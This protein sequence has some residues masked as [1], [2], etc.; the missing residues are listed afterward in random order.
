MALT[1]GLPAPGFRGYS[2]FVPPPQGCV[3]WGNDSPRSNEEG[4]ALD[5]QQQ[6]SPRSLASPTGMQAQGMPTSPTGTI[7]DA[8][9]P[10]PSN[11]V[12]AP[13]SPS[14]LDH[15]GAGRAS[16]EVDILLVEDDFPHKGPLR[17]EGHVEHARP[18]TRN[19]EQLEARD[20]NLQVTLKGDMGVLEEAT[21]GGK[22]AFELYCNTLTMF[23]T[24]PKLVKLAFRAVTADDEATLVALLESGRITWASRNAAGQTLIEVAHE[25]SKFRVLHVLQ[26]ARQE[27]L[28][29]GD[30]EDQV[31]PMASVASP[32]AP[33]GGLLSP[34]GAGGGPSGT[35]T[36]R[37]GSR[38]QDEAAPP[39]PAASRSGARAR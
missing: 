37:M 4:V 9:S 3:G 29:R 17:D 15:S 12:L 26:L 28:E 20:P 21:S 5:A 39:T 27:A 7:P 11:S 36:P 18:D 24:A 1:M 8:R 2:T 16:P 35:Q 13:R 32:R 14:E 10:S 19:R 31:S 34:S 33:G 25:R 30:A 23:D 38:P 22:G 6:M